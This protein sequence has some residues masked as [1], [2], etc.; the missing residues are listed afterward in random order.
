MNFTP[1]KVDPR[2][3]YETRFCLISSNIMN[4][5]PAQHGFWPQM[6]NRPKGSPDALNCTQGPDLLQFSIPISE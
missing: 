3:V 2:H 1:L 6:I 4:A 5:K